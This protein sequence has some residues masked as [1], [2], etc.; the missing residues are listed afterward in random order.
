MHRLA[1]PER[2]LRRGTVTNQVMLL[3]PSGIFLPLSHY[4]MWPCLS[5]NS[6]AFWVLREDDGE[7]FHPVPFIRCAMTGHDRPLKLC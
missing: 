2:S 5:R 7:L 6:K 1:A 3:L 4:R